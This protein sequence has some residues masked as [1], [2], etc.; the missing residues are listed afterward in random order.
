MSNKYS[1]LI[2][3]NREVKQTTTNFYLTRRNDVHLHQRLD[4]AWE[5]LARLRASNWQVLKENTNNRQTV[6]GQKYNPPHKQCQF[7]DSEEISR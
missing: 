5:A 4:L 1:A 3:F 7:G 2:Y 6:R